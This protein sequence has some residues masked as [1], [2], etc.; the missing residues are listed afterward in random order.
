MFASGWIRTVVSSVKRRGH[1][2]DDQMIVVD[3][4]AIAAERLAVER[5]AEQLQLLAVEHQR[6][7][8]LACRRIA[9]DREARPHLGRRRLQ[10]EPQLDLVDQ[11]VG[12]PVVLEPN[13]LRRFRPGL[14]FRLGFGHAR[15]LRIME[16]AYPRRRDWSA[17]T[18][19]QRGPRRLAR[20]GPGVHQDGALCT[21][22][23]R[24]LEAV[25]GGRP[26]LLALQREQVGDDVVG[27]FG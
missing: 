23:N 25:D 16:R 14:S 4:V 1:V 2:V 15:V 10:I 5:E 27:F 18:V 7:R 20:L 13:R 21:R 17:Y 19:R 9:P 3:L 22:S 26:V 24:R 12:R 11:I 6:P 8:A